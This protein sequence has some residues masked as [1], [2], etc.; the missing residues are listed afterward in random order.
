MA[1][2]RQQDP[3]PAG[4]VSQRMPNPIGLPL[5]WGELNGNKKSPVQDL[6]LL[7]EVLAGQVSPF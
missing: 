3:N 7:Q 1:N 6:Y 2:D 5:V 4:I